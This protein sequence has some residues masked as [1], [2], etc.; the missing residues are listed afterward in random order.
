MDFVRSIGNTMVQKLD[1][2][3]GTE[4]ERKVKEATSN[5]GW[6]SSNTT[7]NE[8]ADA[9][10][11]SQSFR[12]VMGILW[13]RLGEKESNW[14]IV[15]KSLELLMYLLKYGSDKVVEDTRDHQSALKALQAFSCVDPSHGDDKFVR[16]RKKRGP[17]KKEG[18]RGIRQLSQQIIDL[19]EDAKRL[20]DVRNEAQKQR[21]YKTIIK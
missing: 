21:V 17:K 9:T 16:E 12:E 3:Q 5:E 15:F 7:K 20:K 13:K 6:N 2:F 8:I 19:V 10:F 1:S 11:N 14:R 18:G 4:M